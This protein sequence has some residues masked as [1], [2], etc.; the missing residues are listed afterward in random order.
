MAATVPNSQD[1]PTASTVKVQVTT[2]ECSSALPIA[3][4]TSMAR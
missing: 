4:C 2:N 1:K 3:P